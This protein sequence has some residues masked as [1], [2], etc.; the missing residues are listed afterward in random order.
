MSTTTPQEKTA[1]AENGPPR[2]PRRVSVRAKIMTL[3]L[4]ALIALGLLL[5]VIAR[6]RAAAVIV[7][8]FQA[9]S[10]STT[11][12]LARGLSAATWPVDHAEL[13]QAGATL[14][15]EM[16]SASYVLVRSGSGDR[17]VLATALREGSPLN[18]PEALPP[19]PEAAASGL[20]AQD[21]TVQGMAIYEVAAPVFGRASRARALPG[22]PPKGAPP[23]AATGAGV[24]AET[25]AALIQIGFR[26]DVTRERIGQYVRTTTAFACVAGLAC[27]VLL[28][29]LMGVHAARLKQLAGAADRISDGDL[30]LNIDTTGRDE[31][32]AMARSMQLVS[33][34]L[35]VTMA[36]LSAAALQV[37]REASSIQAAV[38][39]QS[40]MSSQQATALSQ[41]STTVSE[42]A[43]TSRQATEHADNVIK[44]TQK[45]EELSQEGQRVI[46]ESVSGMG[47]LV[48][49]VRAIAVAITDLSERTAQIGD[50]IATV[51]DLAEQSNLLALNA[52][53]EAVRAGEHGRGFAVVALEMRNL[54]EQSKMAATQVRAIVGE[55]QKGTQA[56]VAVTEEGTKRARSAIALAQ[57]AAQAIE[58][59]AEV[60][61]E[62]S[63][64]AR[65]I[66]NN[67]RQQTIGVDQIVSAI[68]ELS[69]AMADSV[70]GSRQIEKV[71]GSLTTLSRRLSHIAGRY[72]T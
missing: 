33:E 38:T 49:Q 1:P 16:P 59:L 60:I 36:D 72:R 5:V 8:D 70:E 48:E 61:R 51:K 24:A 43:Q 3:T 25:P 34:G 28:F 56:A 26:G 35:R 50:I 12:V 62:S 46:E 54:A 2:G 67:T 55:V 69:S 32:S 65:Q 47:K 11:A 42:I 66:A 29:I 17:A 68:T 40:A 63:L 18:G 39:Q 19:A 9:Q 21:R 30:V 52:S 4:G 71:T 44:I 31:L 27:L 53:L 13:E 37:E 22:S 20:V 6:G 57:G 23:T 45:S 41:T 7:A 14:L 58:G 15:E 64:G 10:R